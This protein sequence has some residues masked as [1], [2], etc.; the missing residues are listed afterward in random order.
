M[1]SRDTNF[2]GARRGLRRQGIY[3]AER[4]RRLGEQRA[5]KCVKAMS[6][7]GEEHGAPGEGADEPDRRVLKSS[8][9]AEKLR[10]ER[11]RSHASRDIEH[12]WRGPSETAVS[13]SWGPRRFRGYRSGTSLRRLRPHAPVMGRLIAPTHTLGALAWPDKHFWTIVRNVLGGAERG[14]KEGKGRL[15]LRM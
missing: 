12:A 11:F 2:G 6:A 10:V 13:Q 4:E 8:W 15:V 3:R 14:G 1:N 7:R 5:E 9:D